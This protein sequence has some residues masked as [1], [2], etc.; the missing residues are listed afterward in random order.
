MENALYGRDIPYVLLM[1]LGAFDAHMMPRLIALYQEKGYRFV[2]I[3]EAGKDPYYAAEVN[4]ALP[5]QPQGLNG[6][7]AAKGLKEPQAPSLLPLD[8][9]CR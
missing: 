2:S 7:M 5:P 4:P 3:E 8:T 9:M 6:A 1:H